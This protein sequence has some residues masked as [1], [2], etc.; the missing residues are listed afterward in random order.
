MGS[1]RELTRSAAE[2]TP[3]ARKKANQ[4]PR[5]AAYACRCPALHIAAYFGQ[6]VAINHLLKRGA[7]VNSTAHPK[8]MTPLHLGA[9][10]G[11]A[12]VLARLLDAGAL[13]S[14]KDKRGRTALAYATKLGH[15]EARRA[16]LVAGRSDIARPAGR[17]DS[18]RR[19]QPSIA[20][21]V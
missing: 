11:H 5:V 14:I 13:P 16:L 21:Q 8:G 6:L 3:W 17:G 7:T 4:R 1:A 20:V 18:K 12:D 10:M 15:E 9:L 19:S 2:R